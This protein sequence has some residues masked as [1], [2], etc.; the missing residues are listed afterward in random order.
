MY[1]IKTS[2]KFLTILKTKISTSSAIVASSSWQVE[3]GRLLMLTTRFD[4]FLHKLWVIF[5]LILGQFI[6]I[7]EMINFTNP[8]DDLL[9]KLWVIFELIIGQF[10]R[11]EMY[12]SDYF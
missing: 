6:E 3:A 7:I 5:E 4:D 11:K 10:I 9:D 2:I 12:L 1:L 8:L